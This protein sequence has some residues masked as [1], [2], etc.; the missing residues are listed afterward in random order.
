MVAWL[1]VVSFANIVKLW[2]PSGRPFKANVGDVPVVV[3]FSYVPF[4][5][6]ICREAVSGFDSANWKARSR[7]LF[8]EFVLFGFVGE[9]NLKDA[10]AIV[11]WVM[12]ML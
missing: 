4:G 3:R 11:S 1:F 2:L 7:V 12:L 5:N 10:G 6:P 8:E 9:I